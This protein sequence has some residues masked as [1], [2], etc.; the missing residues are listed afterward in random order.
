MTQIVVLHIVSHDRPVLSKTPSKC[1]LERP[2]AGARNIEGRDDTMLIAKETVT[3]IARIKVKSCNLP[4]RTDS[5]AKR[6]LARIRAGAQGVECRDEAVFITQETVSHP[7][8]INIMSRDLTF[9]IKYFRTENNR[10][11]AGPVPAPGT[12]KT[13][14]TPCLERT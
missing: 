6:T 14:I 4:V 13:V 8:R 5:V 3:R 1:T 11:L 10:A 12:S 9:V 7:R 2:R